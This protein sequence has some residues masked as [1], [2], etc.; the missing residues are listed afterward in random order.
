MK[1]SSFLIDIDG[2][3]YDGEELSS[4]GLEAIA[5]L[6][7]RVQNVTKRFDAYRKCARKLQYFDREPLPLCVVATIRSIFP[8]ATGT[9]VGY[10]GP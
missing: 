1:I 6:R 5:D 10:R 3:L 7:R 9:Y 4:G 2:T 8:S